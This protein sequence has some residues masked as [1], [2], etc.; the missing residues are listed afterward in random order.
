MEIDKIQTN[1]LVL[2]RNRWGKTTLV[3]NLI[4]K[5]PDY[6]CVILD[7]HEEYTGKQY[8]ISPN[9]KYGPAVLTRFIK[10]VINEPKYRKKLIVIDDIDVYKPNRS[11][12][13]YNFLLC[14]IAVKK[15]IHIE[16]LH[17]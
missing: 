6:S 15:I 14:W 5:M 17:I 11:D 16:I 1:I 7:T 13:F 10:T 4:S 3:K 8:I 12:E 2:S 9:K